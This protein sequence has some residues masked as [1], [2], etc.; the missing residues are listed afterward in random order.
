MKNIELNKIKEKKKI[1]INKLVSFLKTKNINFK[2]ND[3][4][5]DNVVFYNDKKTFKIS[6]HCFYGFSRI[7][8]FKQ[9]IKSTGKFQEFRFI[10]ITDDIFINSYIRSIILNIFNV[11]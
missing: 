4:K 3:G 7:S 6:H 8:C 9:D 1:H 10:E 2:N 11:K 5:L